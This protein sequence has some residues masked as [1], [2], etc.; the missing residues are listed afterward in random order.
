MPRPA[1]QPQRPKEELTTEERGA[2]RALVEKGGLSQRKAAQKVHVSRGA[3]QQAL[4]ELSVNRVNNVSE[5]RSGRPLITTKEQDD[6]L[7]PATELLPSIEMNDLHRAIMPQVKHSTF[8]SRMSKQKL[9]KH[10][11]RQCPLL[12]D[13]NAAQRL[14]WALQHQHYTRDDWAKVWWSDEC[15]IERSSGKKQEWIF[16]YT[17]LPSSWSIARLTKP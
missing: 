5:P 15:S 3:V 16:R 9:W 11:R 10:V 13:E 7:G 17:T 12:T 2:V 14:Q 8:Y 6:T 1:D 4:G